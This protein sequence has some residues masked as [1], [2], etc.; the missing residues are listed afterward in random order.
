MFVLLFCELT[1][2]VFC[3]YRSLKSEQMNISN[4]RCFLYNQMFAES[5]R[6]RAKWHIKM[7][8]VV[9]SKCEEVINIIFYSCN[10]VSLVQM[11]K[12]TLLWYLVKYYMMSVGCH[13]DVA[14]ILKNVK[15]V[16]VVLSESVLTFPTFYNVSARNFYDVPLLVIVHTLIGKVYFYKCP[17]RLGKRLLCL[18]LTR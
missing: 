4:F 10:V 11:L 8:W 7:L 13:G 14:A 1:C 6:S 17:K 3:M 18:F 15:T 5:W 12:G 9:L 16:C 2:F